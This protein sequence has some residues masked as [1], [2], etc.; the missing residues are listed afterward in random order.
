MTCCIVFRKHFLK[1]SVDFFG[2]RS[3]MT[4]DTDILVVLTKLSGNFI[5]NVRHEHLVKRQDDIKTELL[6]FSSFVYVRHDSGKI[7]CFKY[8][9]F[10]NIPVQINLEK[11]FLRL[12]KR[13]SAVL[14]SVRVVYLIGDLRLADKLNKRI[15]PDGRFVVSLSKQIDFIK[16][17]SC[18]CHIG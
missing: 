2:S 18:F 16:C 17:S 13:E 5:A 11:Y 1:T 3:N 9:P 14:D 4:A 15:F 10:R 7:F 8:F 6:L 12:L